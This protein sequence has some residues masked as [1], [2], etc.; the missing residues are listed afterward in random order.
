[1]LTASLSPDVQLLRRIAAG[2][3]RAFDELYQT[4]SPAV[5]NFLLR[6]INEAPARAVFL[7][8]IYRLQRKPERLYEHRCDQ[9]PYCPQRRQCGPNHR[10]VRSD[11]Q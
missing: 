9:V 11:R 10:S 8:S 1:M 2:D 7:C 3:E 6:L 4:Y 5:Y